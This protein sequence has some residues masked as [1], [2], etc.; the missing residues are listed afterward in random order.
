MAGLGNMGTAE[1]KRR[2]EVLLHQS[3]IGPIFRFF[4]QIAMLTD[5]WI[6]FFSSS[7][8]GLVRCSS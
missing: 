6:E 3:E 8:S 5:N 1:G 7:F 2:S 4:S